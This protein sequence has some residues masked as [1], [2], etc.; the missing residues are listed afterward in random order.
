MEAMRPAN[1]T[2]YQTAEVLAFGDELLTGQGVDTNSAW[3][4]A[5][6]LEIGLRVRFHSTVGDDL[7]D[8]VAAV[9]Q[10]IQ[11]ADVVIATGGLGP[12]RD[13]LTREV[14]SAVSGQPLVT[15]QTAIE[16]L[17]RL[18][19]RRQRPMPERN[20]LQAQLPEGSRLIPNPH[21]TAPGIDLSISR[22]SRVPARIIALPG[23]PVEMQQMW[24]QTV[25]DRLLQECGLDRICL[26]TAVMKV[27]GRGESEL[28]ELIGDLIA[29]DQSPRVGITV[30]RATIS[31]RI[32]AEAADAV[33]CDAELARVR[34]TIHQRLGD[35]VFGEGAELELQHVII[36][37]L[38]S[39]RETLCLLEQGHDALLAQWLSS[40]EA[41][42]V[43]RGGLQVSERDAV[44][45]VAFSFGTT[46]EELGAAWQRACQA[47]WLLEV[48]RYPP[49][50]GAQPGVMPVGR[51]RFAV[52]HRP[53]AGESLS[54]GN[55][56]TP[57]TVGRAHIVELAGHP[58]VL[59]HRIAKTGLDF[60]RRCIRESAAPSM[61]VAAADTPVPE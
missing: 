50:G 8:G 36:E 16:H 46:P 31:L 58:D 32:L 28:E 40:L 61:D 29:R 45:R 9:Q 60:L 54:A 52:Y 41:T 56:V 2:P 35:L 48:D 53:V 49:T 55:A 25:R 59:R 21:G 15:D 51:V 23:V 43:Y 22:E 27:F 12:T 4:S 1:Q 42:D 10:A 14:L 38:R 44:P 24:E 33:R 20:R 11:R 7:N 17:E 30:S 57:P 13:D 6:L 47:D 19:A 18:F 3:L 5:R 34:S 37:L 26:K 39:R